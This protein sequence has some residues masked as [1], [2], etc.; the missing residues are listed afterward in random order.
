MVFKRWFIRLEKLVEPKYTKNISST[1]IKEK[2][3]KVGTSP[4]VRRS[5]LNRD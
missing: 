5:K 4:D 2:I 3:Y 1:A